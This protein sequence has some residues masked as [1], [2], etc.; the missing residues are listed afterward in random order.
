MGFKKAVPRQAKL[1]ISFY[2]PPGAGKTFTALLLAE[3]LAAREGKRIAYVDTEESGT[4][5]YCEHVPM[6]LIHPEAF[7]F[8]V[9]KTQGL[10]EAVQETTKLDP[11]TYGVLVIDSISHI[12]EACLAAADHTRVGTVKFGEWTKIKRPYKAW[13]KWLIESPFH[14]IICGRQKNVFEDDRATGDIKKV[15][16][17][18]AAERDTLY[19]P[20][21]SIRLEARVD[22][23]D[24]TRSTYYAFV[25]KDRTGLLAGRT[26]ANL[27]FDHFA[28]VIALLGGEQIA[29]PDA[30][31]VALK[32]AALIEQGELEVQDKKARRSGAL[33]AVY[34]KQIPECE[35][36]DGL[37]RIADELKVKRG[38]LLDEH[39][40]VLLE[41]WERRAKELRRAAS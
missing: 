33:L 15:G 10:A 31:S 34:S 35:A 4:D 25:E 3:G 16:V 2:G 12:W 7:D 26:M 8:D 41:L 30:D 18:M 19:E 1:R 13:L 6:R 14:I 5:F 27:T 17:T 36:L 40:R 38:Q 23:Q 39:H 32:D 24:T 22:S 9:L 37:G 11:A 21:V 28:P 29:L 20:Q